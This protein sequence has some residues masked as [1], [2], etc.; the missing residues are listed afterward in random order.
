MAS[1]V[2]H[3]IYQGWSSI[4]SRAALYL[5]KG[6]P[7]LY[8]IYLNSHI[9]LV[10]VVQG[11]LQQELETF[12]AKAKHKMENPKSSLKRCLP[13]KTPGKQTGLVA[14]PEDLPGG[15]PFLS[16][17]GTVH[18]TGTAMEKAWARQPPTEVRQSTDGCLMTGMYRRRWSLKY[19][20]LWSCGAF[21]NGHNQQLDSAWK[22]TGG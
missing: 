9:P 14:P 21:F 13:F 10:L 18:R 3:S 19:L 16:S 15:G 2:S 8:F 20:H 17:G 12:S 7:H 5:P 6:A 22:K 1:R 11:G 4:G